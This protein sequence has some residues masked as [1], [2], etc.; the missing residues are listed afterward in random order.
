MKGSEKQGEDGWGGEQGLHHKRPSVPC[1]GICTYPAGKKLHKR[2][3]VRGTPG[4]DVGFRYMTQGGRWRTDLVG[5]KWRQEIVWRSSHYLMISRGWGVWKES[6]GRPDLSY[7]NECTVL[8][9]TRRGSARGGTVG[10]GLRGR[11]AQQL[12]SGHTNVAAS[13]GSREVSLGTWTGETPPPSPRQKV[14]S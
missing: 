1:S 14:Q 5:I 11:R 3:F 2:P 9:F 4:K 7:A 12:S 10:G 6:G 13:E 8:P